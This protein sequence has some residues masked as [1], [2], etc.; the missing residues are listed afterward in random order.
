MREDTGQQV[1]A[2]QQ[3]AE[4][5][6]TA[7]VVE[8]Q[9]SDWRQALPEDVRSWQE[10]ETSKSP[11]DLWKQM[12]HYRSAYGRSIRVPG[13]DAGE[14][15]RAKFLNKIREAAPELVPAPNPE[16]PEALGAL[17]SALGKPS[18]ATAYKPPDIPDVDETRIN[19]FKELAHRHNLTQS[20]FEGVLSDYIKTEQAQVEELST[21]HS[22]E[23]NDLQ[24][25]WGLAFE[26]NRTQAATAAQ[27]MGFGEDVVG[28]IA[29]GA[30]GAQNMK[31]FLAMAKALGAEGQNMVGVEGHTKTMMTPDEAAM[32]ISEI[33]KN[34]D[35][36]YWK[37]QDPG[38]AAAKRKMRELHKQKV[39]QN[40]QSIDLSATTIG[41]GGLMYGAG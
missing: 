36:P 33:Q 8:E 13:E 21:R 22:G 12:N 29:G 15:D 30:M 23:Y 14:E 19:Q 25:D 1:A 37:P 9:S 38:H 6:G 18:E 20:Q 24:Q 40:N 34:K 26:Q 39:G 11:D 4:P 7:Q 2:Q 3:E 41:K 35:H 28:A 5:Q 32:Q 27:R 16:D 17:Y 31:A 10:V